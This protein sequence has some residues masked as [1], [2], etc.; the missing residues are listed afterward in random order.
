LALAWRLWCGPKV[1]TKP[2]TSWLS[3]RVDCPSRPGS[4][5]D[6]IDVTGCLAQES[7]TTV[8][9]VVEDDRLKGE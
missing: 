7:G 4:Q 3:D 6:G 5:A 1:E 8:G 2:A 9:E